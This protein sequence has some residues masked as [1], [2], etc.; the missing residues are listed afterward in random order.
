MFR[1]INAA[2]DDYIG[3]GAQA[4]DLLN[5]R[6]QDCF[7]AC[8]IGRAALLATSN[9]I[10]FTVRGEL[11]AG[12]HKPPRGVK[13]KQTAFEVRLN[14]LQYEGAGYDL[15][16]EILQH[17]EMEGDGAYVWIVPDGYM[18]SLSD[19]EKVWEAEG[20]GYFSH[21]SMCVLNTSDKPTR[22]RLEAFFEDTSIAPVSVEFV[23][24]AK[25]SLHYRIDKLKR[26]DGSDLI[27]KDAPVS[28]KITSFDKRVVVQGSRILTS[29]RSSEFGSFGTVVA[30]TPAN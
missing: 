18:A 14:K 12:D 30:W 11:K 23:V 13:L 2:L 20:G 4:T 8:G 27:P 28:Y 16:D 24:E 7:R 26:E 21:E 10:L 9:N 22:C 17:Y 29:G 25:Q 15:L 6:M 1:Q 5:D 3:L 19:V